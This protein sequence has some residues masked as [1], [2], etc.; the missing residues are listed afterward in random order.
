MP[1]FEGFFSNLSILVSISLSIYKPLYLYLSIY[2][3]YLEGSTAKTATLFP[4]AV[5][6]QPNVSIKVLFPAPGGPD[7]PKKI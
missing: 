4:S 5:N 6:L 1:P 3:H 7:N 2:L